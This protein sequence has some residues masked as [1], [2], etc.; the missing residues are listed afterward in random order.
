MEEKI[1]KRVSRRV[2][3]DEDYV[4]DCKH[5]DH[6]V[7]MEWT[8]PDGFSMRDYI[9]VRISTDPHDFL[10][11][12][13]N[14]FDTHNPKWDILPRGP[15][16]ADA[17]EELERWLEWHM[18]RSNMHGGREPA[19]EQLMHVM[20]YNRIC[21]QLDYL[22]QWLPKDKNQWTK[23][24]KAAMQI[25]PF[26]QT[27]HKPANI[28]YERGRY[29]LR[30]V[31]AVSLMPAGDV[32][33]HWQAYAAGE[34]E[35]GSDEASKNRIAVRGAI[36][37][38]ESILD[39]DEEANL[40][41]VDYT[42][43]DTRYVA[44][45]KTAGQEADTDIFD[46]KGGTQVDVIEIVNVE[47]K[48]S[49]LNWVIEDGESDPLLFPLHKGG[50][51]ENQ[52]ILKTVQDT[53]VLMRAW[54]PLYAHTD[55]TGG[56]KPLELDFSKPTPAAELGPGENMIPLNPPQLDP[57]VAQL[58]AQ[59][60][61][62]AAKSVGIQSFGSL[63]AANVQYATINAIVQL[64]LTDLE[65]YKRTFERAASEVGKMMFLWIKETNSSQI[66]YRM[67]SKGDGKPKG[68][69]IMVSP[70]TF[71]PEFLFV[72]CELMPNSPTDQLQ[73]TNMVQMM[74]NM[75][76]PV[77][78]EEYVEFV[79]MGNPEALRD[80]FAKQEIWNAALSTFVQTMQGQAQMALQQQ[81]Q[82]AQQQAQ[83][84]QQSQNQPPA[85]N[86]PQ[87]PSMENAG[88]QGFSPPQGGESPMTAN[89][90]MTQTVMQGQ[91]GA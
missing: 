21:I 44:C 6:M 64:R 89:P 19:R 75:R 26:V 65:P 67:T 77:P 79:G 86:S 10:K 38:I 17:A 70:D 25:G 48:L 30:W 87:Q 56:Q 24:Q 8:P 91:T 5:Y 23:D 33:E 45:W 90:Q 81:Q 15:E 60:D 2:T 55:P 12:A 39:E 9:R 51:W 74:K 88:G 53:T 46:D 83:P 29:G 47:N 13:A 32:I 71:D 3:L 37:Q 62:Q 63:D 69:Q 41:V 61:A 11:T 52:N 78:D 7:N 68:Q 22:P 34:N 18:Q 40:T 84:A 43:H 31:A 57:G 16:D 1:L 4:D 66:G 49:F 27:N 42:D 76:L 73:R 85:P 82:A 54:Y 59:N 28:H 20:L 35:K 58:S 80:R 36:S 72:R 50:I 14:I